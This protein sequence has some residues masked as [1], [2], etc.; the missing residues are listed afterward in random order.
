MYSFVRIDPSPEQWKEIEST[1]DAT[2]DKTYALMQYVATQNNTPF[3]LSVYKEKRLYGYFIGEIVVRAGWKILGSPFFGLGIAHQGLSM[4]QEISADE[5]I[6]IYIELAAYVFAQRYAVWIE[7]AD[8]E[9]NMDDCE[10]RHDIHYQGHDTGF[11]DLSQDEKTLQHNL[12]YKSCR[13]M[14][15]K[16]IK[17][18]VYVRETTDPEKFLEIHWA[19]HED[20]MKRKGLVPPKPKSNLKKLIDAAYP[21]H[22]Q[23]LEAVNP[24]GKII[25]TLMTTYDNHNAH[26]FA[27]ASFSEDLKWSPNELIMWESIIRSKSSGAKFFNMSG[28]GPFKL[29]FG[30]NRLYKPRL[31]FS[32]YKWLFSVRELAWQ[33][34]H[35]FRNV[36]A[37][38]G[39]WMK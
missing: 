27:R 37:K 35:R 24:E 22:L 6:N 7:I 18:G 10:K 32:K 13:Y 21:E 11:V 3:V 30:S 31:I 23:L 2:V 1:Y 5:R 4:L 12:H 16:A 29:K 36:F 39:L 20:V 9:L 19:Q 8:W 33:F 28:V 14:I 34:Y 38:L 15:N 26:F 17:L 25:S